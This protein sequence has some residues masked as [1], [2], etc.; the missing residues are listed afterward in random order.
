MQNSEKAVNFEAF[1]KEHYNRFY[2]FAYQMIADKEICR[3]IV[4]DSFEQMWSTLH[5]K[6]NHNWLGF[7]YSLIK[8]K[9]IDY[10]RHETA[11]ER[12]ISLYSELY[13]GGEEDNEWEETESLIK[14]I[15]LQITKLPPQTRMVLEE[16]YFHKKSYSEVASE[17]DISVSMVHKHIATALKTFREKIAKN[18]K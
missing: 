18:S 1:F 6:E 2:F 13:K 7:M 5:E 12:Y 17:L 11:K 3:D 14:M 9:C 15:Q 16:C 4:S 8:N 10:I